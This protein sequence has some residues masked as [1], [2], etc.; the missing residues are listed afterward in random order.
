M[1][2]THHRSPFRFPPAYW[3]V[4]LSLLVGVLTPHSVLA[5]AY[6]VTKTADTNDGVCDADCSLREAIAAAASTDTIAFS[7]T[8]TITLDSSLKELVVDKS[9]TI[10]GP[11]AAQ[12]SISGG[13]AVRVFHL[14][15]GTGTFTLS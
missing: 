10:S 13:D 7:V 12:L 15:T 5:A 14:K 1:H 2:R 4:L 3:V 8:G 9:L 11:G 6:V